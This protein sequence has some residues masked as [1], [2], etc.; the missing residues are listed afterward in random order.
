MA[1]E[2]IRISL[3]LLAET[4]ENLEKEIEAKELAA[5]AKPVSQGSMP[6]QMDMFGGWTARPANDKN[7]ALLAKKLDSTI[8]RVQNLLREAGAM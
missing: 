6:P 7:N 5:K 2:D 4:V 8:D 1:V 3:Q